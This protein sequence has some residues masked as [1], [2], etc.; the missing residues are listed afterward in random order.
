LKVDY[1]VAHA[2]VQAG[3]ASAWYEVTQGRE[4]RATEVAAA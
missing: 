2:F 3:Q 4:S 1:T